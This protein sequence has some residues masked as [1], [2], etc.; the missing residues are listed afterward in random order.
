MALETKDKI[1]LQD[2]KDHYRL[3]SMLEQY[4]HSPPNLK[5]QLLFQVSDELANKLIEKYYEYDSFVMRELLGL[6][7]TQR[8][9]KDLDEISEKTGSRVKS[10]RRQVKLLF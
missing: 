10:C 2:I 6:R 4:L 3:F 5:E 9:R 1:V 7:L 8:Q